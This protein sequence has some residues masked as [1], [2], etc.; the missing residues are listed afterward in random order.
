[1]KRIADNLHD[2]HLGAEIAEWHGEIFSRPTSIT[3]ERLQLEF[4]FMG[5]N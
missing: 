3:E 4:R 2:G 1:M 5:L